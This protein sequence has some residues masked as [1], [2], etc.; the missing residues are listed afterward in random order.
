MSSALYEAAGIGLP[1]VEALLAADMVV[2]RLDGRNPPVVGLFRLVLALLVVDRVVVVSPLSTKVGRQ[3]V[4]AIPGLDPVGALPPDCF[5]EIA[6][7]AESSGRV[8]YWR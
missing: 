8:A 1:H 4:P 3:D 6:A 2:R 5:Q 7:L